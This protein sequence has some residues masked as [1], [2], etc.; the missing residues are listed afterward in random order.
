[1]ADD[2]TP[3]GNGSSQPP[4][5]DGDKS[6]LFFGKYKTLEEA[7]HGY[8]ELERGYHSKATEASNWKAI[9]DRASTA[10][11]PAS[12]A[13]S[14]SPG[15]AAGELTEFY[16]NPIGWKK[17][18]VSEAKAEILRE[19]QEQSSQYTETATR[20]Q[21]WG[22]KNRDLEKHGK[23]L[24]AFVRDTDPRLNLETRLDQAAEQARNYLNELRGQGR[25]SQP[26]PN[27]MDG[28][29]VSSRDGAPASSTPAPVAPGSE[30]SQLA[31]YASE[32][33]RSRMKRPGTHK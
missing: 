31:A 21:A 23:I 27:T 16:A 33:N 18:L 24:Q 17:K 1:M 11:A 30:E 4:A 5:N 26:D 14:S 13:P 7:E 12:A 10:P 6:K 32:R 15:D 20:I 9:A 22:A 8:K 3:A 2:Q 19:Q 29:P 25:S 28:E